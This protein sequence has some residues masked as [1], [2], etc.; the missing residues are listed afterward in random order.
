MLRPYKDHV[1]EDDATTD[2]ITKI[3]QDCG[4]LTS[5]QRERVV[6]AIAAMNRLVAASVPEEPQLEDLIERGLFDCY[7]RYV[8]QITGSVRLFRDEIDVTTQNNE[9][10][11]RRRRRLPDAP[12]TVVRRT[13]EVTLKNVVVPKA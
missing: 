2:L 11:M 12:N 7:G 5:D 8:G 4:A 10:F 13:C 6:A 3:V 1:A 9:D